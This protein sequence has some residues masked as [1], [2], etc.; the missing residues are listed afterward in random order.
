MPRLLGALLTAL[1]VAPVL[2]PLFAKPPDLPNNPS[3]TVGPQTELAQ[4]QPG[5]S[6]A[7]ADPV[8]P[9]PPGSTR[10]KD[11]GVYVGSTWALTPEQREAALLAKELRSLFLFL[12]ADPLL[13][14]YSPPCSP[15]E[16]PNAD[17]ASPSEPSK[18]TPVAAEPQ[19]I[20]PHVREQTAPIG[21]LP[22]CSEMRSLMDNLV[23]L[24][25]ATEGLEEARTLA[26]QGRFVDALE[27][28][29]KVRGLCPGSSC[30]RQIEEA[31]QDTLSDAYSVTPWLGL[32]IQ[33]EDPPSCGCPICNWLNQ[34]GMC[35]ISQ[36]GDW[37][38]RFCGEPKSEYQIQLEPPGLE[39]TTP[40]DSDVLQEGI[41]Q[42]LAARA[43]TAQSVCGS[44]EH[45]M[46][47]PISVY[48]VDAPLSHILND[49]RDQF[50]VPIVIDQGV[51]EKVGLS[52]DGVP[53]TFHAENVPLQVGLDL[54]LRPLHL[55]AE[56]K[57]CIVTIGPAE[58]SKAPEPKSCGESVCPK[59]EAMHA[60]C[61]GTT[62]QVNG[63][64]KACYLAI[65]EKRFEKAADLARQAHALDPERVE[66][67]PLIY[68]MHLI[69]EKG[70]EKPAPKCAP[71]QPECVP[72]PNGP[73]G[74]FLTPAL[75]GVGD[76]VPVLDAILTGK[77]ELNKKDAK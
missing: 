63:L 5:V 48:F 20:C 40:L 35:W 42:E 26:K 41:R 53:V 15:P 69:A 25:K 23:A 68:K 30:D 64:M 10:P 2:T 38:K 33:Q 14:S 31:Y 46:Q 55:H 29:G 11:G 56:V 39:I 22:D 62:E 24:E 50:G 27:C 65:R 61:L 21:I 75:P 19:S 57:G 51:L 1:V 70:V 9:V 67:D 12:N 77:D 8:L 43:G 72:A 73:Q 59:A 18:P 49:I 32:P 76:V 74:L 45:L 3:I 7:P 34:F 58:C 17:A 44:V 54:M 16:T 36:L 37:C 52:P 47:K 13:A 60:K 6:Y 28:L 4:G 66:A 71:D